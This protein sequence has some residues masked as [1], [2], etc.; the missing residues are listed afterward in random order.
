MSEMQ[1]PGV[2]TGVYI[3]KNGKILFGKRRGKNGPGTWCPPG[4]K[5]EMYEKW[6]DNVIRE[7]REECGMEIQNIRLMTITNDVTREWGT[8]FVTLHFAAHWLS[9]EP[10]DFK[11]ESIGE[12][13]WYTWNALPEPLFNPTRNFVESGYNPLNFGDKQ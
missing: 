11:H 8:H 6:I 12:W 3:R 2:G 4:G 13:G 7:T 9:G 5:V 1:H 10:T